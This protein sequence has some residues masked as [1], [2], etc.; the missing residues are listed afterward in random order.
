MTP[1]WCQP[2]DIKERCW[3]LRFDDQD[4]GDAVF[5]NEA[6]ARD[7]FRRANDGGWNCYLFAAARNGATTMRTIEQIVTQANNLKQRVG[8][9]PYV[10]A[11]SFTALIGLVAELAE[12]MAAGGA[13][14][15]SEPARDVPTPKAT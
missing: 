2:G 3:L 5:T 12:H 4:R 6:E 11:A 9:S 10:D 8:G 15:A 13:I 1:E 14:V 7:M